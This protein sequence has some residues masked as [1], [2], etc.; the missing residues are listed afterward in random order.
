[1]SRRSSYRRSDAISERIESSIAHSLPA[2]AQSHQSPLW[3]LSQLLSARETAFQQHSQ[4]YWN[5]Q[6]EDI[7]KRL[8]LDR[9]FLDRYHRIQECQ[10][11]EVCE[12]HPEREVVFLGDRSGTIVLYKYGEEEGNLTNIWSEAFTQHIS[13]IKVHPVDDTKL[14]CSSFDGNVK[15]FDVESVFGDDG[16]TLIQSK[17]FAEIRSMDCLC[18]G[19]GICAADKA[20]NLYIAST[21][22]VVCHTI[23]QKRLVDIACHPLDSNI[24]ITA[25]EAPK[26]I[27]AWDA[28]MIGAGPYSSFETP[29]IVKALQ[30]SKDGNYLLAT[31]L[32]DFIYT[33][34][35]ISDLSSP[36]CR[37]RHTNSTGKWIAD[38]QPG[39]HPLWE[40]VFAI[41]QVVGNSNSIKLLSAD[42]GRSIMNLEDP[43]IASVTSLTCFHPK[44]HHLISVS[45]TK[46]GLWKML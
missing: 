46:I 41:G 9:M 30:F 42:S 38:F 35:D 5:Y 31:C 33:F 21:D 22:A 15:L 7:G 40:D 27:S 6:L 32:D 16:V 13:G 28:R 2:K 11:F 25:Q 37:I 1:M 39:F 44:L 19:R 26:K 4:V 8:T 36:R 23:S 45:Y 17:E 12:V 18:D 29:R 43:A 3:S 14:I 34:S 10:R 20:G 24:F